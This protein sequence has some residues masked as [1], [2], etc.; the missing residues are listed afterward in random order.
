M[1]NPIWTVTIHLSQLCA[2]RQATPVEVDELYRRQMDMEYPSF[3]VFMISKLHRLTDLSRTVGLLFLTMHFRSS[4]NH[5][6]M[7]AMGGYCGAAM[8]VADKQGNE[9]SYYVGSSR[10]SPERFELKGASGKPRKDVYNASRIWAC[11][12]WKDLKRESNM[13]WI[14]W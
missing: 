10:C 14:L 11:R 7:E 2:V 1:R 5:G 9:M 6:E 3:S 13:I 12:K 4:T 8:E